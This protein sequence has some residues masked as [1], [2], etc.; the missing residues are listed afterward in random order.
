MEAREQADLRGV[1]VLVAAKLIEADLTAPVDGGVERPGYVPRITPLS[2]GS[3]SPRRCEE[4]TARLTSGRLVEL[5]KPSYWVAVAPQFEQQAVRSFAQ[6]LDVS[7]LRE[8][9]ASHRGVNGGFCSCPR[10]VSSLKFFCVHVMPPRG[11]APTYPAWRRKTC[12]SGHT[13]PPAWRRPWKEDEKKSGGR[14]TE[15][16]TGTRP[17]QGGLRTTLLN[18]GGQRIPHFLTPGCHFHPLQRVFFRPLVV[19][20]PLGSRISCS[21]TQAVRPQPRCTPNP[22]PNEPPLRLGG[23]A[24]G[25]SSRGPV[26]KSSIRPCSCTS[27][28]AMAAL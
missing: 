26:D 20:L 16:G 9:S 24:A 27:P 17:G 19:A 12:A 8:S 23:G 21:A 11:N 13:L 3:A 7:D 22:K 2:R 6:C 14:R 4:V 10:F 25:S 1:A 5:D 28:A 18:G 15:S